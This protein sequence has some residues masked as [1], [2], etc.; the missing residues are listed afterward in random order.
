[1]ALD[2]LGVVSN[3]YRKRL[4]LRNLVNSDDPSRLFNL[5]LAMLLPQQYTTQQSDS[6][7]FVA[8]AIS[9]KNLIKNTFQGD[10]SGIGDN[11]TSRAFVNQ[12]Y[13]YNKPYPLGV[14]D[15]EPLRNAEEQITEF[16]PT[17]RKTYDVG[18]F[19]KALNINGQGVDTQNIPDKQKLKRTTNTNSDVSQFYWKK[20]DQFE[21]GDKKDLLSFTQSL[22]KNYKSD[23]IGKV[24]DQSQTRYQKPDG[25]GDYSKGSNIKDIDDPQK[26]AREFTVEKPYN[27][28][29]DL[30]RHDAPFAVESGK[31][32][33]GDDGF[34]RIAPTQGFKTDGYKSL[35]FSLENLAWG[36]NKGSDSPQDNYTSDLPCLEKGPN[37]GRIM[38]FPPYGI[39][40]T[41]N[42]TIN[43]QSTNFVGRGEP[44][45]TYNN[46]ER[47]MTLQFKV[48]V[49]HPSILNVVKN[50]S[51][52][53]IDQFF[54]ATGGKLDDT[55]KNKLGYYYKKMAPGH[56]D[57]L[58]VEMATKDGFDVTSLKV[59]ASFSVP[60]DVNLTVYYSADTSNFLLN[61]TTNPS[62]TFSVTTFIDKLYEVI[63]KVS[64]E[65]VGATSDSITKPSHCSGSTDTDASY[66]VARIDNFKTYI[67][68]TIL[69]RA[70]SEN[71]LAKIKGIEEIDKYIIDKNEHLDHHLDCN[72]E[73]WQSLT[74]KVTYN[75]SRDDAFTAQLAKIDPN[76]TANDSTVRIGKSAIP[77]CES[78]YFEA[79]DENTRFT[80]FNN[81][82]SQLDYF[83]PSF[84]SMTPEGF[85]SRLTFLLQCTR[86]GP[87]IQQQP[88]TP[89]NM[90]FGRPPVCILKIGD[91]YYTKV[92]IDSVNISYDE[93][94]WD[95][96]PEGIGVQPMIA[97]VDLN[98]K[99]IG[100]SSLVGPVTK[101]QNALSY[102]FFANTE[103]YMGNEFTS[104]EIQEPI[105]P[106]KP[107]PKKKPD[108][109]KI[110]DE[111]PEA[112]KVTIP[113]LSG[114]TGLHWV[115]DGQVLDNAGI[116]QDKDALTQWD[117]FKT[118]ASTTISL[119]RAVTA[120]DN[121]GKGY[122]EVQAQ[123]IGA[124]SGSK[125]EVMKIK[126]GD[127][128][129]NI[130]IVIN[131]VVLPMVIKAGSNLH[132]QP[133]SIKVSYKDN[134][135][136]FINS[137]EIYIPAQG[138]FTGY[139]FGDGINSGPTSMGVGE[140]WTQNPYCSFHQWLPAISPRAGTYWC[141]CNCKVD[142]QQC[143]EGGANGI[144]NAKRGNCYVPGTLND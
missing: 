25:T 123:V 107:E 5:G 117:H 53:S 109:V 1:M 133:V 71:N 77:L 136:N 29:G 132:A 110:I 111:V 90:A 98:M 135:G 24:I 49:D 7:Q 87:S 60:N 113:S 15:N 18:A 4:L 119:D 80:F 34:V 13:T 114:I 142:K 3:E 83:H 141:P 11:T 88:N 124:V 30:I 2:T 106:P 55:I 28:I 104:G 140:V 85:N 122:I 31:S 118:I 128:H 51:S 45:Y 79:M 9:I 138:V 68:S 125:S 131:G 108:S 14:G 22:L 42:S 62:N 89:T 97:T 41:D 36:G 10:G 84:H 95:L 96:N 67:K 58:N 120:S 61:A 23:S 46:T 16:P 100:G 48:L 19:D 33:L 105:I 86:Q 39:T 92:V 72:W 139:D 99:V 32:V 126:A 63:D 91:F 144:Y 73:Q 103:V 94:L 59:N 64:I 27:T 57:K 6:R 70:Q 115:M 134:P 8:T 74:V 127:P 81:V 17:Q 20:D 75:P 56:K 37:G 143:E 50:Q 76:L 35:M 129:T 69:A 43:W 66:S 78:E 40:I 52:I 47:S 26:L 116:T 38:W 102:H 82:K 112:P 21:I 65:L 54:S 12:D 137:D 121:G 93:N 44:I 130:N 101:L